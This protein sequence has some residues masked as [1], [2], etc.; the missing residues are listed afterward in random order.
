MTVPTLGHR[1]YDQSLSGRETA[2][3]VEADVLH[4]LVRA[5]SSKAALAYQ[6]QLM[7]DGT[8]LPTA[9]DPHPDFGYQVRAASVNAVEVN[10]SG[11]DTFVK[12]RVDYTK[13]GNSFSGTP[14]DITSPDY[15]STR[16]GTKRI[17]VTIPTFALMWDYAQA[18]EIQ[19]PLLD[20]TPVLKKIGRFTQQDRTITLVGSQYYREVS[21]EGFTQANANAIAS[22]TG[23]IHTLG[24]QKWLFEGGD[25]RQVTTERWV[26]SYQWIRDP[27]NPVP[28]F[29]TPPGA[30]IIIG[31][32]VARLPFQ[33][34]QINWIQPPS[35]DPGVLPDEDP[36]TSLIP[37]ITAADFGNEDAGGWSALPG[38]GA[39]P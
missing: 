13:D 2:N 20:P 28:V 11:P 8:I 29:P 30:L 33:Q 35:N 31:P 21:V 36:T 23:N 12:I 16:F 22:Q 19:P 38:I 14:P 25:A 10:G 17:E 5:N 15:T 32:T 39:N 6:G 7:D 37:V 27:G 9:G 24:G 18:M 1:L 3:G 26:I 34:Y 4:W